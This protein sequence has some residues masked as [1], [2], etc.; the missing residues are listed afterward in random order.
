M[1]V[2][3]HKGIFVHVF[4]TTQFTFLVEMEKAEVQYLLDA[5]P[6]P[7]NICNKMMTML[8]NIPDN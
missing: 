1:N 2:Y 6:I 5:F 3:F 7:V 8:H 4:T